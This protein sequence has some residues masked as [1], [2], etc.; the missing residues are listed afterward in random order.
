MCG[1]VGGVGNIDTINV[2]NLNLIQKHRGPDH[3][4][5]MD[6]RKYSSGQSKVIYN[7]YK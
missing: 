3:Q 6:W 5:H 2:K 1:I 4:R 7:R